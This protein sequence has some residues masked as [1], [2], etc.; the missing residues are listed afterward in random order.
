MQNL[1]SN[2]LP[3]RRRTLYPAEVQGLILN[4][5]KI[6]FTLFKKKTS[7]NSGQLPAVNVFHFFSLF[8]TMALMT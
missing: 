5:G 6:L 3:L 4:W 2:E 7:V 1:D 8:S